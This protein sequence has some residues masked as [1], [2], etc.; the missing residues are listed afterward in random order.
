VT[1]LLPEGREIAW[2]T[3]L[4]S[5][6]GGEIGMGIVADRAGAATLYS[7]VNYP[8]YPTTPD[9]YQPF[10]AGDNLS[11]DAV[12]TKLHVT[13]ESL[14]YSTHFEGTSSESPGGLA[15]DG[16]GGTY[17]AGS[18]AS[19]DLP[20]TT[21]AFDHAFGGTD[22]AFIAKFDIPIGPWT[23]L[24][25][26]SHGSVDVPSLVGFGPLTDG[27][28]NGLA[29]RGALAGAGGVLVAGFSALNQPFAGGVLVPT[30][31]ILVTVATTPLGRIDFG[32]TWPSGVPSGLSLYLQAWIFDP[33]GVGGTSASNGLLGVTP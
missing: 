27:S 18:T 31:D 17:L 10:W 9:A 1:K 15:L 13:G 5:Q 24:A 4:H 26:G 8:D 32:F 11:S 25:G 7:R 22:E 29:V 33:A 20:I 19:N 16:K 23:L 3:F 2:S 12:L 30:P 21:G 28:S 6:G 14:E